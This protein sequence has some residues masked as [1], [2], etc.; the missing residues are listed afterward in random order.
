MFAYSFFTYSIKKHI[1][2][3]GMFKMSVW[4]CCWGKKKFFYLKKHT[5]SGKVKKKADS[6]YP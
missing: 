5:F 6:S 4:E 1:L 2:V 3:T